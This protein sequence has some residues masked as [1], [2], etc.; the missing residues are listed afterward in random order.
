MSFTADT[1]FGGYGYFVVPPN[2]SRVSF[3][4]MFLCTGLPGSTQPI[5]SLQNGFNWNSGLSNSGHQLS[6]FGPSSN[7]IAYDN[8][9]N[10]TIERLF[11]SNFWVI[12]QWYYVGLSVVAGSS[13]DAVELF[14]CHVGS[15]SSVLR[16]INTGGLDFA[17][18]QLWING[19]GGGTMNGQM[20][21]LKLWRG[22]LSPSDHARE[23]L[24]FEPYRWGDLWGWWPFWQADVVD[25]S[26]HGHTLTSG[27]ANSTDPNPGILYGP[28]RRRSAMR[29]STARAPTPDVA[30]V[31]SGV[32][33]PGAPPSP[34]TTRGPTADAPL[35]V[36]PLA[37]A[38][39][40][41]GPTTTARRA[42]DVALAAAPFSLQGVAALP[43]THRSP[44]PYA[45]VGV[46]PSVPSGVLPIGPTLR[47]ATAIST[48][49]PPP[50]VLSGALQPPSI[51]IAPTPF[52]PTAYL[53]VLLAGALTPPTTT[54]GPTSDTPTAPLPVATS[55]V[56]Q[57]SS[58]I[59]GPTA[60][61][62]RSSP[63]STVVGTFVASYITRGVT[64]II[65]PN[66][67]GYSVFLTPTVLPAFGIFQMPPSSALLPFVQSSPTEVIGSGY[68]IVPFIVTKP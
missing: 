11:P 6:I 24:Q 40:A 33:V 15:A 23:A 49:S 38:G 7:T 43:Y 66:S 64:P 29:A 32:V 52:A 30:L 14:A 5:L 1:S 55:G 53:S 48:N 42:S 18:D 34:T 46:S 4:I 22:F 20:C 63:S 41:S 2:T 39:Q 37:I 45:P 59:R 47:G 17:P 50:L 3:S 8:D 28:H 56:F 10:S 44:T 25:H 12:N 31:P 16:Q 35:S 58:I 27:G 68:T 9:P 61:V 13:V 21:A 67:S 26:G 36:A 60:D 57:V 62:P 65:V 51:L 54:R 19:A